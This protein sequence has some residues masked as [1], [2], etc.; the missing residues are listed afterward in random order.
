M[1]KSYIFI[2]ITLSIILSSCSD[3]D[4]CGEVPYCG[5]P[6]LGVTGL[7]FQLLNAQGS[8]IDLKE[9]HKASISLTA[10]GINDVLLLDAGNDIIRTMLQAVNFET[11]PRSRSYT[12]TTAFGA[13]QNLKVVIGSDWADECQICSDYFISE[14]IQNNTDTLFTGRFNNELIQIPIK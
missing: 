8:I 2:V 6:H 4:D 11:V 7:S 9:E 14:I 5:R 12:L 13:D 10:E 1:M 3:S